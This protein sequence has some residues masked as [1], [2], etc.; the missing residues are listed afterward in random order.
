MGSAISVVTEGR[1][2][3]PPSSAIRLAVQP[4]PGDVPFQLE[5][6]FHGEA[7][8]LAVAL[9]RIHFKSPDSVTIHRLSGQ[10]WRKKRPL[11]PDQLEQTPTKR[12]RHD[13]G[14]VLAG[15]DSDKSAVYGHVVNLGLIKAFP[16]EA[17][18][19]VP[20]EPHDDAD[21]ER[22]TESRAPQMCVIRLSTTM[23]LIIVTVASLAVVFALTAFLPS[24]G[25]LEQPE[26]P[27]GPQVSLQPVEWFQQAMWLEIGL[28][29]TARTTLL[30]EADQ[31]H[32]GWACLP[33]LRPSH[34]P[35][36]SSSSSQRQ[37][38][39]DSEWWSP[40]TPFYPRY[41]PWDST[42]DGIYV[43]E[44]DFVHDIHEVVHSVLND[45]ET[46]ADHGPLS[47][48]FQRDNSTQFH[49]STSEGTFMRSHDTLPTLKFDPHE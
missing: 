36:H 24:G 31:E 47:F 43:P 46:I 12:Q 37:P 26:P 20:S 23:V 34:G 15:N 44:L 11:E 6:C 14:E 27:T 8:Q 5:L 2:D 21:Q 30:G 41:K 18:P 38:G 1:Q 16:P 25:L 19:E 33:G 7:S 9:I 28:I 35:L 40:D 32:P 39:F 10:S 17:C 4:R 48:R 45:L 42:S 3:P 29:S 13:L 49:W 22:L